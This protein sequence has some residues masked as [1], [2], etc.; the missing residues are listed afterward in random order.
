MGIDQHALQLLRHA[1]SRRGEFGATVTLGRQSVILG[2]AAARRWIG[3]TQGGW[4]EPLLKGRFGATS[5]DSIDNSAYEG[6]TIVA[7]FNRPVAAALSARFDTVLDLGCTEHIFD[8]AQSFRNI[9]ALCKPGGWIMHAVPSDGCCGHGFFQFTPELFHSWYSADNG[10][11]ETQVFLADTHDVNAW[12]RVPAPQNG[13]RINIRSKGEVYVLVL[14]RYLGG[15]DVKV[16]QSDYEFMWADGTAGCAV[17]PPVPGRLVAWRERL[18]RWPW[19]VRWL[20]QLDA[21]LAPTGAR[22]LSRHPVLTRIPLPP[23]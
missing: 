18:A 6:A 8:V 5:V 20:T 12:Y 2:P 1:H 19:A 14:T 4:G 22:T 21:Y 23:L 17:P 16:Q 13:K 15:G 9:M 7:D 10:F 3:S 11:A